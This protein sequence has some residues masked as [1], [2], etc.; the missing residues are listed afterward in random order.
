[1][2]THSEWQARAAALKFR[3]QCWINGKAVAAASGHRFESI[4]PATGAVIVDV[5]RG[6]AEDIDRA[7]LAARAAFEDG[8]WSRQTPSARKEVLLR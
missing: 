8:R 5:A 4:D 2:F 7:V 3:N 6:G 1:M